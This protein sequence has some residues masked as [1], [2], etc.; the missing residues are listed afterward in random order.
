MES[1]AFNSIVIDIYSYMF[2]LVFI[3]QSMYASV[4]LFDRSTVFALHECQKILIFEQIL[5]KTFAKWE[6][7]FS[8]TQYVHNAQVYKK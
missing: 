3:I 5:I 1:G 8:L 2:G 6:I 4:R 7:T